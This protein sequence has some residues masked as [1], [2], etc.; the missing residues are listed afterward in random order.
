MK[1]E[2]DWTGASKQTRIPEADLR[3]LERNITKRVK[4]SAR[5]SVSVVFVK[6]DEMQD[7]NRTYRGKDRVTDVLSFGAEDAGAF[8]HEESKSIGD[9]IL[10]LPYIKEFA[11]GEKI[12]LQ[13]ELARMLVH[14]TLHCLGYDH[15]NPKDAEKMLPLQEEIIRVCLWK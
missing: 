3:C 14:G 13:E 9:V 4:K 5:K 10:C 8:P 7:L 11:K 6:P 15:I 12:P 2:I 1:F